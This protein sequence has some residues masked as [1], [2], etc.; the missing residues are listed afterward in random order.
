MADKL[1]WF[2][3]WTIINNDP[4]FE[5]L[6]LEDLGRWAKLGAY[7]AEHGRRG[8]LDLPVAAKRLCQMM[9]CSRED[10]KNVVNRLPKVSFEEG[11]KRHG[12]ITVTWKNWVKYQ[13]DTTQAKRQKESRSKRRGEERR[14]EE[15]RIKDSCSERVASS[16]PPEINPY[17]LKILEDCQHLKR[18]SN[19]IHR[20]FWDTFF[21]IVEPYEL[22]TAWLNTTLRRWNQWFEDNPTRR[23]RSDKR[24]RSRLMGWL[25]KDLDQQARRK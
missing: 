17:V 13:A 21:A 19:G 5:E 25:D 16:E 23:S 6:S 18:L 20:D 8:V 15:K 3:V 4:D 24:L 12:R 9:R 2:K 11:L 14:E 7:I 1:R 22:D 10:L